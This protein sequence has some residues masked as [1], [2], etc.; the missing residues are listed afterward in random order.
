MSD[1]LALLNHM[2]W[3]AACLIAGAILVGCLGGRYATRS[4]RHE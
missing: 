3:W 4:D 2:P 1:Q